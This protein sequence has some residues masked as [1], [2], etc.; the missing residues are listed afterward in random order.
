M[1]CVFFVWCD[2]E[3]K[4]RCRRATRRSWPLGWPLAGVAAAVEVRQVACGVGA[5]RSAGI[6][7]GTLHSC[8]VNHARTASMPATA[9]DAGQQQRRWPLSGTHRGGTMAREWPLPRYRRCCHRRD[10]AAT[11]HAN[12]FPQV[13]P[14]N[15]LAM[16]GRNEGSG[17]LCRMGRTGPACEP[18]IRTRAPAARRAAVNRCAGHCNPSVRAHCGG[19]KYPSRSM[20]K[21]EFKGMKS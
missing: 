18:S 19:G 6:R 10:G 3:E 12:A 9:S 2:C 11:T 17:S 7:R 14:L 5:A 8:K 4:S 20:Y 16:G 13:C 1:A 21:C 15:C